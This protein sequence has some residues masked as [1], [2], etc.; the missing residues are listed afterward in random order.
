MDTSFF[1]IKRVHGQC[2]LFLNKEI[3]GKRNALLIKRG[4]NLGVLIKMCVLNG[5]L[6][7]LQVNA[8]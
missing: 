4:T 7:H 6:R 2:E 8:K 1:E 3:K 5:E